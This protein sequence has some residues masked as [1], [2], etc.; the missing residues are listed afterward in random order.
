MFQFPMDD[1]GVARVPCD[2]GVKSRSACAD[3]PAALPCAA[4]G[5]GLCCPCIGARRM[6]LACH[7]RFTYPTPYIVKSGRNR[8]ADRD[9]CWSLRHLLDALWRV[10]S[11]VIYV[12][13]DPVI[14]QV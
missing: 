8:G 9:S 1:L 11:R 13:P 10:M 12:R 6:R 2:C 4:G 14:G 5:Y 3:F 7:K